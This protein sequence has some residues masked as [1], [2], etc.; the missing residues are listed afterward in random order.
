VAVNASHTSVPSSQFHYLSEIERILQGE[1]V[2]VEQIHRHSV[3]NVF[4]AAFGAPQEVPTDDQ[5][6]MP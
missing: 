5:N 1:Q 2:E 3:S 4:D 6:P